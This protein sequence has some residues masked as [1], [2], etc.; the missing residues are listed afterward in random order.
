MSKRNKIQGTPDYRKATQLAQEQLKSIS[1][2]PVDVH[3]I[4]EQ[5]GLRIDY[6]PLDEDTSGVLLIDKKIIIVN[7][8]HH[9]NRQRFSI[10]HELGHF[11]LHGSRQIFL[12]DNRMFLRSKEAYEGVYEEEIEANTFAAELLMPIKTIREFL[13]CRSSIDSIAI[14]ALARFLHVSNQ[15]LTFRLIN[16]GFIDASI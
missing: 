10:A 2:F 6:R 7:S 4:A 15:A 1:S 12:D 11:L 16:L 3:L 9:E 5:K 8:N 14:E 13:E